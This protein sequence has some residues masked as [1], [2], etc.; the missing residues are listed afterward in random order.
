VQHTISQNLVTD[1]FYSE[2]PFAKYNV[3]HPTYTYSQD[4]YTR[5]LEGEIML[6]RA[7]VS[8]FYLLFLLQIKSGPK[9]R[10]TICLVW[11][12]ILICG[13]ISSM[14]DM[15]IR[16]VHLALSRYFIYLPP[17]LSDLARI[18][19]SGPQRS[20]LQRLS[21]TGAKSCLDRR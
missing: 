3:Q 2:Y 8:V 18:C 4:E 12:G 19:Y 10:P 13:G 1:Y 20:L 15:N 9:R 5:F 6:T 21:Q 17:Y 7:P 14:T 11:C 16:K